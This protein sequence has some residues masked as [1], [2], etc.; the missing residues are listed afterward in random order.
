MHMHNYAQAH[1]DLVELAEK[2]AAYKKNFNN[3]GSN[4]NGKV[5]NQSEQYLQYTLIVLKVYYLLMQG[6][7]MSYAY[8]ASQLQCKLS[9][10]SYLE[11]II[12]H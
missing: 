3:N 11:S 9:K 1:Q 8:L 7:I 10:F 12:N 5:N 4:A 6:G 2:L